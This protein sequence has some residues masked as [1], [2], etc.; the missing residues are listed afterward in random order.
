MGK[1]KSARDFK[2]L[3]E[4]KEKQIIKHGENKEVSVIYPVKEKD[5]DTKQK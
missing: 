1:K 3:E 2:D 4:I 5:K